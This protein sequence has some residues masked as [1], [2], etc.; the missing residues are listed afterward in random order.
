[1]LEL[2]ITLWVQCFINQ[3]AQISKAPERLSVLLLGTLPD[4]GGTEL[5]YFFW[6]FLNPMFFLFGV[7]ANTFIFFFFFSSFKQI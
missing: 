3:E 5:D 4:S 6:K 2:D 1:M 7:R